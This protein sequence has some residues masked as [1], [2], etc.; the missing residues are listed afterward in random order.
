MAEVLRV[1]SIE[2][3]KEYSSGSIVRLPDFAEGRPFY[4][5]LTRPSMMEMVKEDTIPNDLLVKANELF[6]SRAINAVTVTDKKMMQEMLSV[7]E[8]ICAAAFVEPT[9]QEIKEAGIKLTD[10]QYMFVFRYSQQGVEALG[11]FRPEQES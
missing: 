4:A 11:S 10:Q 9:W 7:F 5:R 1:T 8:C 6:T 2:E 3:L